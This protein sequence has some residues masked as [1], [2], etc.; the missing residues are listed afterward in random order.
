MGDLYEDDI[1][2][3]SERQARLL[4]DVAAGRRGNEAPDWANVIE[5]IESVG[6][7]GVVLPVGVW[8]RPVGFG[9][10]SN[11]CRFRANRQVWTFVPPIARR[12][13]GGFPC[14]LCSQDLGNAPPAM[15]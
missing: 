14:R 6:R 8:P 13:R 3:W 9:N 11:R 5:E 12:Q 1:L 15:P 4:C 2:Q 7:G 10:R